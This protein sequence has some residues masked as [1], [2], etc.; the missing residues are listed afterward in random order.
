MPILIRLIITAVVAFGLGVAT[1]PLWLLV[2]EKSTTIFT[3][4][5]ILSIAILV[6]SVGYVIH[7]IR[8][9]PRK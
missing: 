4:F 6:A 3:P 1:A 2:L 7:V 9:P 5:F 8:H